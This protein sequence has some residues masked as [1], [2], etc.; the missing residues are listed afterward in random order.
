MALKLPATS[1]LSRYALSHTPLCRP[2][3]RIAYLYLVHTT[4][5]LLRAP[6]SPLSRT[7]ARRRLDGETA[8]TVGAAA[9]TNILPPHT[10]PTFLISC[11]A[12]FG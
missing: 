4:F 6:P 11:L 5:T 3:R 7:H 2:P 1:L 9:A 8:G 10:L 12:P